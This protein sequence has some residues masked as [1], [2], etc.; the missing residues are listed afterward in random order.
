[1]TQVFFA[2]ILGVATALAGS[3]QGVLERHFQV[4]V[5]YVDCIREGATPHL[6]R[7]TIRDISNGHVVLERQFTT[8]FPGSAEFTL[9]LPVGAYEILAGSERCTQS[10]VFEVLRQKQQSLLLVSAPGVR[11]FGA[12]T[13]IAGTVPFDGAIV[14]LVYKNLPNP[15]RLW[16]SPDGY[17][18]VPAA[19]VGRA[20]YAGEI[21]EGEATIRLYD[22]SRA[23]WIDA[24]VVQIDFKAQRRLP[25]I[26]H[27]TME[28]LVRTMSR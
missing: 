7:A 3:H 12:R 28:D 9:Q 19:V 10:A 18:Q 17:Y 27:I 2:A 25:L 16:L 15:G 5:T 20:F 26:T 13:S 21:P 24:A 14:Y 8:A 11:S 6:T 23:R 4:T 22:A 1:M